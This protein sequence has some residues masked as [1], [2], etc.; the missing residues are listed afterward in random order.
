MARFYPAGKLC[1]FLLVQFIFCYR[2]N[3]QSAEQATGL[4]PLPD[5]IVVLIYENFAY[6]DI[7]GSSSAPNINALAADTDAALFTQSFAVAHPSQPNYLAMFSGSTQGVSDDNIP[8]A[9]P[10]TTPNLARELINASKTFVTYSE[11]LPSI[12]FNGGSSGNYAR[13]HNPVTNWI[14]TG[15]NQVSDSTS[16]PFTDFPT[17]FTTLPT[18]SY[19]VPNL[20]D[21][22][23]NLS[24]PTGDTWL[25]TNLSTYINWVK[26][27]NSLLILTFDE[28]DLIHSNNIATIFYGP[29][30]QGGHYSKH[31]DHYKVL[32]TIEDIYGLTYAANDSSS[33]PI[34][35]CWKSV[36]TAAKEVPANAMQ[37]SIYPNPSADKVIVTAGGAANSKYRFKVT[38]VTGHCSGEYILTGGQPFE[39]NTAQ[40]SNGIY[41]YRLSDA[42]NNS[43]TGKFIEQ[44]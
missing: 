10:F 41:L 7:I 2:V 3:S 43:V 32:S 40:Y 13:K 39:L 8:A 16:R 29:M 17:D 23:H 15:A 14:G 11:D 4:L 19:V 12:G 27:H 20:N 25:T 36:S 5:H 38:D 26:A 1:I 33:T 9:N 35:N 30:V 22:M 42:Q 44:H 21:D 34:T 6:S 24:I 28:D 37:V 18:V 31:I